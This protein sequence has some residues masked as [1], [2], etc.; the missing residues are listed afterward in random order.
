MIDRV[1]VKFVLKR[2]DDAWPPIASEGVW[3]RP[4]GG[5]QY[6]LDNVPWF[7]PGIAFGDRVRARPD[8]DGALVVTERVEWSGRYT[9]RVIPL[10]DP[11]AGELVWEVIR[12]FAALGVFCE[13]AL[14]SY[15]LVALDIPWDADLARIKALLSAGETDGRWGYEESCIDDRWRAA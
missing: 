11:P 6:E 10:G 12:E 13:G 7:A 15:T 14:P 1:K 2:E 3:A 9:V 5:D 8:G 4:L